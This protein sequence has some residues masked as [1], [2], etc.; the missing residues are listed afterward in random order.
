MG[1]EV[2]DEKVPFEFTWMESV[3]VLDIMRGGEWC[4]NVTANGWNGFSKR[5]G[6]PLGMP[7]LDNSSALDIISFEEMH[8]IIHEWFKHTTPEQAVAFVNSQ[9]EKEKARKPLT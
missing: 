6:I 2:S 5:H 4:G 3:Y 8:E 7:I 9:I 1:D